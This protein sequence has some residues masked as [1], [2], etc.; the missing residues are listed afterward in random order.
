M[1]TIA[2]Q[3]GCTFQDTVSIFVNDLSSTADFSFNLRPGCT[4]DTVDFTNLST[5]PGTLNYSWDFGDGNGSIQENPSH[6]YANQSSY[7]VTL[8]VVNGPCGDTIT[9]TVNISHPLDADFTVNDDSICQ[10]NTLTFTNTSVATLPMTQTWYFG[11]GGTDNTQ[12]AIHTY[13]NS[14]VFTAMLVIADFIGCM[15]TATRTIVVDTNTFISFTVSD[16]T[17]CEGQQV[18]FQSNYATVGNTGITWDFGDGTSIANVDTISHAYDTAGIYTVTLTATYRICPDTSFSADLTFNAFPRV[19]LGPDT[20]LCPNGAPIL[21][22]DHINNTGSS[23]MWNTGA[24]TSS[25][26]V[27]NIGIYSAT[28]DRDGCTGTDSVEVFKDCYVDIPNSFTPNGDG[29]NDYFL[30]RQLLSSSVTR[31]KMSIYNRWGELIYETGSINGRGW[32]GKMNGADQPTGVYVYLIEADFA[33]NTG[34]RYQ[35]NVTLLR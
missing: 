24:T 2:A 13:T 16:S 31:F 1:S 23:Y 15:D 3:G 17:L 22:F 12:T 25:I 34:E 5:G 6:V 21:L 29:T 33:N 20:V 26:T 19:D 10:N 35:G 11:D 32:D 18:T 7:T 30:P 9:K 27:S 14:G 28:V 8:R 4:E